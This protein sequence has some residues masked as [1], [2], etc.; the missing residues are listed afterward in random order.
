MTN[1]AIGLSQGEVASVYKIFV[2]T[3]M[4]YLNVQHNFQSRPVISSLATHEQT[5]RGWTNNKLPS[6]FTTL[7]LIIVLSGIVQFS[8][9]PI[10]RVVLKLPD[11]KISGNFNYNQSCKWNFFGKDGGQQKPK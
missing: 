1:N 5:V 10:N 6:S 11:I 7:F 3:V 4:K 8:I 9:F 2:T